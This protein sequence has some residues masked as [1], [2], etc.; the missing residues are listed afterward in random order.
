MAILP[1]LVIRSSGNVGRIA[2]A[3]ELGLPCEVVD[4]AAPTAPSSGIALFSRYKTGRRVLAQVDPTGD[5]WSMQP[6]FARRSIGIAAGAGSTATIS[7]LRLGASTAGTAVSRSVVVGSLTGQLRRVGYQ[8]AAAAGSSA[9]LRN[10]AAQFWRGNGP[11]L[12]GFFFSA[13]FFISVPVATT[14]WFVGFLNNPVT[15]GN[16][17]PSTL[18]NIIGFG[19][20]TGDANVHRM[21]NDAAGAATSTDLGANFPAANA[22]AVYEARIYCAPNAADISMSL[23]RLDTGV[24]YGATVNAN[25]PANNLGLGYQ[26]WVNNDGTAAAAAMDIANVYLETPI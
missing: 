21:E 11:G 16:V 12:G 26:L 22:G 2:T 10:A 7:A 6:S 5:A 23:E 13:L 3:D 4:N 8:T 17:N 20:D 19:A 9:G 15:I 25:I 1:P 24:F 14:R 18:T